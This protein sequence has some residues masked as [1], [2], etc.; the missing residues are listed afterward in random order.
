[1]YKVKGELWRGERAS[2]FVDLPPQSRRATV[3]EEKA[4]RAAAFSLVFIWISIF[5]NYLIFKIKLVMLY[6]DVY[7]FIAVW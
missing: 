6:M 4:A 5:Y 1:M 2:P 7:G 3:Q